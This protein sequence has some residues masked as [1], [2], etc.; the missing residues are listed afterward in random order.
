MLHKQLIS[1]SRWYGGVL[2]INEI[3]GA[4]TPTFSESPKPQKL[5]DRLIQIGE[6]NNSSTPIIHCESCEIR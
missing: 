4:A 1:Q 3:M 5:F 2:Y 6:C